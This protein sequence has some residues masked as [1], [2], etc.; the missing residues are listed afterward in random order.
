[1]EDEN[2]DRGLWILTAVIQDN[3]SKLQQLEGGN[4]EAFQEHS[5]VQSLRDNVDRD[6]KEQIAV[7]RMALGS[8]IDAGRERIDERKYSLQM[9]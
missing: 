5:R 2:R 4:A 9:L 7:L 8:E 6:D 1:M 3:E